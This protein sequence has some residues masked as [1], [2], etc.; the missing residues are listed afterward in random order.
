MQNLRALLL[1][2]PKDLLKKEPKSLLPDM[3]SKLKNPAN[4]FLQ[5]GLC[6]EVSN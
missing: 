6:P 3:T 5:L 4:M 2:V 1:F